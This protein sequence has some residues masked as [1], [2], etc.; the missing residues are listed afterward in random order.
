AADVDRRPS[1]RRPLRRRAGRARPDEPAQL[2]A[3]VPA[4]GGHDARRLRG[5]AAAR[6]GASP[7]GDHRPQPGRGRRRGRLR[8]R[9]DPAPRL[10]A[11]AAREPGP[12]PAPLPLVPTSVQRSL[13]MDIA[14]PLFDGITALDAI[15]PYEVLSRLPGARIRFVAAVPGPVRTDNKMLTLVA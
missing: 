12:V 4:R 6:G 1:G 15:G 5:A 10:P 7:A 9:R 14:I 11:R 2:R 13:T 8:P 3:G